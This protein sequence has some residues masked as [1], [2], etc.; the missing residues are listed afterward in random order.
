VLASSYTGQSL[1]ECSIQ[2][3][4]HIQHTAAEICI[5]T[6]SATVPMQ[7]YEDRYKLVIQSESE[8]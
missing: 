1:K 2:D 5:S 7:N 8:L 3:R 6:A 4:S